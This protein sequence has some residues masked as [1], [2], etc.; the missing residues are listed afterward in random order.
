[1][2][3]C[4]VMVADFNPNTERRK[5]RVSY[6]NSSDNLTW[7]EMARRPWSLTTLQ[8]ALRA[9]E[10]GLPRV[11]TYTILNVLH[12]AGYSWQ[13]NRS[14]SQTGQAVRKRKTGKVIVTDP[15]TEAKKR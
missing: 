1:M 13:H 3:C 4:R 8:R 12:E 2:R 7:N 15:D 9:A 6:V 11:S 10:D 14:W 5:K